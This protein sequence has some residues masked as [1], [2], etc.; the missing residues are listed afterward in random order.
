MSKSLSTRITSVLGILNHPLLVWPVHLLSE[1]ILIIIIYLFYNLWTGKRE[2]TLNPSQFGNILQLYL[3][4]MSLDMV[5][6]VS[7]DFERN[8]VNTL[9]ET[10]LPMAPS[11]P[12]GSCTVVEL[13]SNW[14]GMKLDDIAKT[15]R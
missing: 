9:A 7:T 3:L 11:N 12:E 10:G 8:C 15:F 5:D 1:S 13:I 6:V 14:Q 4:T 2:N